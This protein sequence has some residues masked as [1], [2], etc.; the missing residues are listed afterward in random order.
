MKR[1]KD[2]PAN[3][4]SDGTRPRRVCTLEAKELKSIHGGS[5]NRTDLD[6]KYPE[7]RERVPRFVITG[8]GGGQI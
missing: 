4:P 6:N 1:T 7:K 5:G 3:K 8:G 2:N